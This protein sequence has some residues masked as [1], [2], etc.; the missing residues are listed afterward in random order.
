MKILRLLLIATLLSTSLLSAQNEAEVTALLKRLKSPDVETRHKAMFDLQESLDPRIP[1]ACLPVLQQE[2]DSIRR[3]AAR[4]IG[5]RWHQI[6]KERV[7]VFTAALKAQLKSEHDGLVNM[8]RRGI[9]LLD[10]SYGGKMLSRSNSKRWV[11]YERHGLPCLIDTGSGTEELLGFG[12]AAN[13]AAAWGNSEV[14]P[15]A[16]WH[17]KKDIVALDILQGRKLTTV[18]VW[19]HGKGLRRFEQPEILKAL[20]YRENQIGGGAGFFTSDLAWKGDSLGFHLSFALNK[21][22]EYIDHEATLRWDSAKDKL[23]VTSDKVVR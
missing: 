5:S 10:R 23:I 6:P 13:L 20:G 18:W 4:A 14:A 11:I 22:G 7:P 17:P 2:G 1:D 9:A 12:S 21:G 16:T 8:A 3:L 15:T 19:S